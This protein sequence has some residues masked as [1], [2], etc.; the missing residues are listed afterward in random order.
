M[1][2]AMRRAM[3][4]TNLILSALAAIGPLHVE[5]KY[6]APAHT[7]SPNAMGRLFTLIIRHY[8]KGCAENSIQEGAY[9]AVDRFE[10]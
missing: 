8:T 6:I 2:G 9:I 7:T 3:E 5:D 4:A 10:R 1:K